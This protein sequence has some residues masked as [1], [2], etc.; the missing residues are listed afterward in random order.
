VSLLDH[1]DTDV[2]LRGAMSQQVL[3]E[4]LTDSLGALITEA[5]QTTLHGSREIRP[6]G[7]L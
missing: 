3:E 7:V 2:V 6:A 5:G 1:D 4:E